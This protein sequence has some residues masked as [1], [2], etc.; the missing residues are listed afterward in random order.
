[1]QL[2]TD[3]TEKS[4]CKLSVDNPIDY[5][6]KP[7]EESGRRVKLTADSGWKAVNSS[8]SRKRVECHGSTLRVDGGW[9]R[10]SRR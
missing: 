10:L 9:G 2:A 3:L 8:S 6:D 7:V 4:S 5:G 1:M